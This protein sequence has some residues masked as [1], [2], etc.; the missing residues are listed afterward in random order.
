MQA[1]RFTPSTHFA[2]TKKV[3]FFRLVL[4]ESI[5]LRSFI[6]GDRLPS[7]EHYNYKVSFKS[8][9]QFRKTTLV[10]IN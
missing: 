4:S 1:C 7:F 6:W 10:Y 9:Y 8:I 2:R 5:S 3:T